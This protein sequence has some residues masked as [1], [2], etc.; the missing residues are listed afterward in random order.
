M[1]FKKHI[2]TL[3]LIIFSLSLLV[4]SILLYVKYLWP[5]TDYEQL[6]NT[7]YDL[8]PEVIR[9]NIYAKDYFW[10][11]LFFIVV[12]PFAAKKL[13]TKTQSYATIL[14]LLIIAQLSGAVKYIYARHTTSN[15]YETEYVLPAKEDIKT[16]QTPRN[17]ILIFLESFEQNFKESK[18]DKDSI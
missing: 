5:N 11:L 14:I 15:I 1:K 6:I 2:S 3:I 10:G 8:T 12:W 4:L 18:N 17:L 7:L 13:S 9:T 16:A